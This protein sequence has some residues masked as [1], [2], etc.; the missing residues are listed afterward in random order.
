MRSGFSIAV[1]GLVGLIVTPGRGGEPDPYPTPYVY[2][3]VGAGAEM[4]A[5]I[6]F[7]TGYGSRASRALGPDGI[8]QGARLRFQPWRTLGLEAWGGA[9]FDPGR[10]GVDGQAAA[11]EIIGRLL[12]QR[13]HGI[14]LDLGAGYIY[15]YREEHVP[16]LRL[17]LGRSFGRW[18]VSLSGLLEVPV[19]AAGRDE[20]DVMTSLAASVAVTGGL[21]LGLELA[22]EDLEG[23]ED[24]T[25]A[26]GG[27]K[28]L[29]GPTLAWSPGSGLFCK[30][31]VAALYAY[32]ANQRPAPGAS[33]PPD[34]GIMGR[35][36]LGWTW[37]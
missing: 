31:N 22:A 8:E 15:D 1:V 7:E 20:A 3:N 27:A 9:L 24:A 26:E 10:T 36:I 13:D 25:E 30:L 34:W 32:R 21:R 5:T 11:V 19:G 4:S 17:T 29:F 33:L 18:D 12:E 6:Q 2:Q 14:N 16:R 28:F 23:L 35:L 37:R